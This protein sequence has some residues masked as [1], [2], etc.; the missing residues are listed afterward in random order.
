MKKTNIIRGLAFLFVI[1]SLF[2]TSCGSSS[3]RH[4]DHGGSSGGHENHGGSSGSHHDH[5]RGKK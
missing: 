4:G 3:S 1:G 2:L 5:G